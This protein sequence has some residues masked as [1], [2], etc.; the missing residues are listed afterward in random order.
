MIFKFKKVEFEN[1]RNNTR[2][3]KILENF[4]F[5]NFSKFIF[6]YDFSRILG[7]LECL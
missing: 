7:N 4:D 5:W 3:T 6:K 2:R 1:A